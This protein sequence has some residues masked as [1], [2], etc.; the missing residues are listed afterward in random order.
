M[1]LR[2][3]RH[4]EALHRLR[5]FARA[6]D[7][8]G[9]TQSA[10]SRSLQ[11]LEAEL[12]TTLF[13]RNTHQVRP[14][15]AADRL[16][17]LAHDVLGAATALQDEARALVQPASGVV[18]V[19]A[20]PYPLQPLVSDTVAAFAQAL[21]GVR[22]EVVV[23]TSPN[24]LQGLLD[25]RLDLV[26]CDMS[27]FDESLFAREITVAGLPQEPLRLVCAADH[28]AATAE[29]LDTSLYPWAL[30]KPS[31]GSHGRFARPLQARL[32]AGTFPDYQLD[33]TAACLE[34]VRSGACV[35]VVPLS[36]AIRAC[37]DGRLVH[38]AL[39]PD[40]RTNDGVHLLR[41]RTQSVAVRRFIELLV[42]RARRLHAE[43]DA[44]PAS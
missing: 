30:P 12:G 37:R 5:S 31:P 2:R 14:T 43:P 38:R 26:V 21:P 35:T 1:D 7:E 8:V 39:P 22:V 44:A 42:A 27:K 19:G 3:L 15:E 16:V 25:R 36:L 33:S 28:P 34:V 11:K 13:D 18:R 40:S 41:G 29:R 23:G 9:L 10:L 20:G 6:A 24:L 4:F 32:Q 17:R